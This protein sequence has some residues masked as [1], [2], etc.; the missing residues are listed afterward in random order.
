MCCLFP[1]Q[2]S[3]RVQIKHVILDQSTKSHH[4]HSQRVSSEMH[5]SSSSSDVFRQDKVHVTKNLSHL[6]PSDMSPQL[7]PCYR[8]HQQQQQSIAIARPM[9]ARVDA[10]SILKSNSANDAAR[11][12]GIGW[13]SKIAVPS[14]RW[15]KSVWVKV[16]ILMWA[17][18]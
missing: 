8:H 18:N 6:H 15:S 13:C 4:R 1:F 16:I 3:L 11:Y 2:F 7:S 17:V 5:Y 14:A 10:P 9:I 12:D